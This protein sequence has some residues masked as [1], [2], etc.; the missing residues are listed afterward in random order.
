MQKG[1]N[2]A[3]VHAHDP[4]LFGFVA[5]ISSSLSFEDRC[6][7]PP[8]ASHQSS[9]SSCSTLSSARLGRLNSTPASGALTPEDQGVP[10][11][12]RPKDAT[13]RLVLQ[14]TEACSNAS[15]AVKPE[16]KSMHAAAQ[17][18]LTFNVSQTLL[19]LQQQLPGKKL[20]TPTA[21]AKGA[22]TAGA[23]TFE[24]GSPASRAQVCPNAGSTLATE[25]KHSGPQMRKAPRRADARVSN[26]PTGTT[27][28][29]SRGTPPS[30]Q[31]LASMGLGSPTPGSPIQ[32]CSAVARLP[33]S[34][35]ATSTKSISGG[36]APKASGSRAALAGLRPETAKLLSPAAFAAP[37]ATNVTPKPAQPASPL[38]PAAT[39][40]GARTTVAMPGRVAAK[41]VAPRATPADR[42]QTSFARKPP[43]VKTASQ[44]PSTSRAAGALAIAVASKHMGPLLPS[45]G[46]PNTV[47]KRVVAD[48]SPP[49]QEQPATAATPGYRQTRKTT[50]EDTRTAAATSLAASLEGENAPSKGFLLSEVQ[51]NSGP[52]SYMTA[53]C[54]GTQRRS[55]CGVAVPGKFQ[56]PTTL[57]LKTFA[58]AAGSPKAAIAVETPS[59]LAASPNSYKS[60]G[61]SSYTPGEKAVVAGPPDQVAE[62]GALGARLVSRFSSIFKRPGRSEK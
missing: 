11:P 15:T 50:L 31:L 39:V 49:A 25:V 46:A 33:V 24:P 8:V 1:S 13:M 51:S 7:M 2:D 56:S 52:P 32:R 60:H 38:R 21:V 22:L 30:S 42:P 12:L 62:A 53:D 41:P 29:T 19:Q 35:A 23:A 36:S 54:R 18:P 4:L 57:S 10:T 20:E 45:L 40:T 28:A 43:P 58:A 16:A 6:L 55:S 34:A 27:K 5:N 14:S 17:S 9:L 47:P 26:A 61:A 37:P 59:D 44:S 48:M 3:T